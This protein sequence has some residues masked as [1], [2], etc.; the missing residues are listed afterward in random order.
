MYRAIRQL[1]GFNPAAVQLTQNVGNMQ[2]A[3]PGVNFKPDVVFS[4]EP[5]HV[6]LSSTQRLQERQPL[7]YTAAPSLSQVR[8]MHGSRTLQS[9]NALTES[10]PEVKL[11]HGIPPPSFTDAKTNTQSTENSRNFTYAITGAVI[12]TGLALG[13]K[14]GVQGIVGFMSITKDMLALA[15]LEMKLD[16]IP[17]GKAVTVK[18]RGKPVFV[19]HRTQEE[20]NRERSVDVKKL[21][22]PQTD[23]DRTV[24]PEWLVVVG[25]CTHL[26]CVPIA[27]AG[28]YNGYYCPC[29][30]SHYDASGRI[31][32]GPA[33]LN[34]EVPQVE[35]TD[36]GRLIVG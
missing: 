8:F 10:K 18:W 23:E 16:K 5:K 31:R 7:A 35:F 29:H 13:A 3:L 9:E 11:V 25:V 14:A 1:A 22:D 24:K 2:S 15:K 32:K 27:F 6:P 17:E 21:R 30:G 4:S 20:V 28:E 36:D 12:G 19:R 33:P 26:G 34:L